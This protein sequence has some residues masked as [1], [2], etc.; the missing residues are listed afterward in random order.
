MEVIS[1]LD[2]LVSKMMAV[3]YEVL[4]YISYVYFVNS[5]FVLLLLQFLSAPYG[6]YARSGWGCMLN[7]KFAWF[8]QELPSFA[9]PVILIF[10]TDTWKSI[11]VCSKV[12]LTCFLVHYF[13]RTFIF[14]FLIR[15]GKPTPF[16]T[17]SMA[18]LFCVVN[19]YLQGGYLLF[20]APRD[21]NKCLTSLQFIVGLVMFFTGMVIN[22][23][24]DHVLR[25]LRKPGE[26]GYQIPRGGMFNYVSGANFFGEILEWWG[27]F[28]LC[29]SLPSLAFAVF[30]TCNIGP[31][32]LQHHRWYIQKFDDYP[33]NR[34]AVIPFML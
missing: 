6:R 12:T 19:G 32:A 13:Q 22:I 25:N 30:T 34:K 3:D 26:T 20:H 21:D 18:F 17:F 27:F 10:A 8:I 31:R 28:V 14:S 11:S 16:A 2:V 9:V 33:T 1:L 29:P 4:K 24:S 5:G 23:H 7:A 15:G